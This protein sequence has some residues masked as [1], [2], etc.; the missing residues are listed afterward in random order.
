MLCFRLNKCWKQRN[1]AEFNLLVVSSFNFIFCQICNFEK[2][3]LKNS[4]E[5]IKKH[6]YKAYE[7]IASPDSNF[8]A[9]TNICILIL[10][11]LIICVWQA[12][13]IGLMQWPRFKVSRKKILIM[14]VVMRGI[15]SATIRLQVHED[16][17]L[18]TDLKLKGTDWISK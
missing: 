12:S 10:L 14:W 1:T 7:L 13:C 9:N 3:F 11:L 5:C 17:A 15:E 2:N 4:D 8:Q 16:K 18:S 6:T